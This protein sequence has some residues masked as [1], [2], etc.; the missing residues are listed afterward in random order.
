M[1]AGRFPTG[2]PPRANQLTEVQAGG[3]FNV[4]RFVFSLLMHLMHVFFSV[5]YGFSGVKKTQ[6]LK[7]LWAVGPC[8]PCSALLWHRSS[9]ACPLPPQASPDFL[10]RWLHT[11]LALMST[12]V[13][14]GGGRLLGR[15]SREGGGWRDQA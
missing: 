3:F 8:S 4:S 11:P 14:G 9:T 2:A 1:V 5:F 10:Q 12:E 6:I 15:V 13:C 7:T